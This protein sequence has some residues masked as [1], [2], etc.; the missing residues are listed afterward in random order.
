MHD[1]TGAWGEEAI[2]AWNVR[3]K[4]LQLWFKQ[5][6]MRYSRGRQA[7]SMDA[8][9]ASDEQT[10][11]GGD[12]C[13]SSQELAVAVADALSACGR[14]Q[15]RPSS[16]RRPAWTLRG[17]TRRRRLLFASV[18]ARTTQALRDMRCSTALG[19]VAKRRAFRRATRDKTGSD[20]HDG[21][22]APLP[23]GCHLGIEDFVAVKGMPI[24]SLF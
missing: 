23:A 1:N 18:I 20:G 3:T 4:S 6:W 11:V 16:P 9:S 10:M 14:A 21:D 13:T 15:T 17:P 24:C 19:S 5:H 2:G 8:Q 7:S 12:G 22:A